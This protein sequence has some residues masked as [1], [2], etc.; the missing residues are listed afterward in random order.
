MT[1]R[2]LFDDGFAPFALVIRAFD[3]SFYLPEGTE[4]VLFEKPVPRRRLKTFTLEEALTRHDTGPAKRPPPG[5][6][7]PRGLGSS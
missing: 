1:I 5:L 4:A 2:L 6:A 3:E 7:T